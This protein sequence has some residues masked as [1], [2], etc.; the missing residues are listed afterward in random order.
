MRAVTRIAVLFTGLAIALACTGP[1][2]ARSDEETVQA[3]SAVLAEFLDLQIKEIPASLLANAEG[4]VIVP[5]L[6]KL[7]F[8]LGGQR[9]KGVVLVRESD[10]AWR[11]PLFVTLTGGSIGWQI[12]AQSSDIVLIFKTRKS[13]EG[14]LRGKF[15]LG[16]DAAVAAGPVGRRAAAATDGELRA[17]IY[18]YSRSRGLFAGISIDGSVLQIDDEANALYYPLSPAGGAQPLPESAMKLVGQVARITAD[19]NAAVGLA[20][21]AAAPG[22]GAEPT[23]AGPLSR[24]ASDAGAFRGELSKSAAAL[25]PLLDDAWRR[26]LALP[27][28]VYQGNRHPPAESLQLCLQRY[29]AIARSAQYRVL[30]DRQEFQATHAWLL[31]YHEA[32][33]SSTAP[34]LAL[35]PPPGTEQR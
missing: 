24:P 35:P 18:S 30:T 26:Y 21:Q 27:A 22:L 5:D 4:V 25:N 2:S 1:A 3:S 13:V 28:E 33:S 6:I 17:E 20:P 16:A 34:K 12:G 10:G 32:L 9:G 14:L 19:P 7:G 31:A 29:D 15:T 23:P 11:A 8:V